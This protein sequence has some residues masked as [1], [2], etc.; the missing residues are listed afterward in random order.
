MRWKRWLGIIGVCLVVA[1]LVAYGFREQP[2]AVEVA[3]VTSAPLRVTIEEEGK[4]RVTDRFLVSAPV[5][6]FARRIDLEVDD[7]VKR[8][9]LIVLL[10]P[11]A[12]RSPVLD[13]RSRAEA[14]ARVRQAEAAL[15]ES[16][17]RVPSARADVT[18]WEAQFSRVEKLQHSGDLAREVYD[19]ALA[20]KQRAEA[21]L[22]S[23]ERAVAVARAE[24]DAARVAVTQ[25]ATVALRPTGDLAPVNAPVAG[26]VLRVLHKSEG[27]VNA[28][29]PL[30]ELA[31]A[32]S[33]EIEVEVLSADAVRIAPGAEVVL[34]RW[35]G[36]APLEGTVRTVEPT[37]F[38]K[39][40]A[41][42]VE[43]QRVRVIAAITSPEEEWLRLG[44]GYR[45]EAS[46]VV[47]K[48][49][50][51]LQVPESA[52]FRYQGGWAVF[53]KDGDRAR[54]REVKVGQRNGLAAQI[55]DG[56]KAGEQVIRHPD[57]TIEENTLLEARE[58]SAA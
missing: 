15:A 21:A 45:V 12:Q 10:E 7:P 9:Q 30:V 55:L 14:E 37:A 20:D 3:A 52:I 22:V 46:F 48:A 16:V 56:L 25:P 57:D 13:A 11:Q 49:T 2:V 34:E 27:P 58:V 35:G 5:A 43:E 36:E 47:W 31:N 53:V 19:K 29:D 42:G 40:S 32:R 17:S 28:G 4:T 23:A 6:G 41:L 1:L 38:T 54:R 51:V 8:G 26:R 44:D 50:D 18:Y 24:L 39:V 33:L